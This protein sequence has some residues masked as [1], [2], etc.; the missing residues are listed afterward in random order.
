MENLTVVIL[1]CLEAVP[2]LG[3]SSSSSASITASPPLPPIWPQ[4]NFRREVTH[5]ISTQCTKPFELI[6]MDL[7]GPMQTKSIQGNY[8]HYMASMGLLHPMKEQCFDCF[9]HFDVPVSTQFDGTLRAVRY[10]HGG[11]FLSTKFTQYMENKGIKHQ[12]TAP[13]TPQQMAEVRSNITQIRIHG[14]RRIDQ[15]VQAMGSYNS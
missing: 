4:N 3:G 8:F 11:R 13:N 14:I 10:A 9:K 1:L 7:S 6:H 2:F 15:G 12:L 5:S